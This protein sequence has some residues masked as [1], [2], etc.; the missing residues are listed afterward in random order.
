MDEWLN[1]V[2]IFVVADWHNADIISLTMVKT[3]WGFG[4]T[5]PPFWYAYH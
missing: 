5:D 4:F 2:L 3:S 1:G